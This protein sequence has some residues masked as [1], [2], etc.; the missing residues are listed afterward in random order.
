LL[1]VINEEADRLNRQIESLVDLARVE[2]GELSVRP[3]WR[4]LE[5][6]VSAA[7]ERAAPLLEKHQV[8]VELADRLPLVRVDARAMSELV[9]T[10]LDNA[11]KYSPL[12]STIWLNAI[13]DGSAMVRITVADQGKGI[14]KEFHEKVFEKFFRVDE[15][16]K[17]TTDSN[18]PVGLGMGL[19]IAKGIIEAHGG[20]IWIEDGPD[21][22]G[23]IFIVL[24]PVGD[25]E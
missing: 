7:I 6:V 23:T 25:E 2:A 22:K 19:A 12:G 21:G 24:V 9:F 20:R 14:P 16:A 13:P 15:T 11:S 4:T 8:K 10:L 5:E 17:E 3:T 18:R 1:E